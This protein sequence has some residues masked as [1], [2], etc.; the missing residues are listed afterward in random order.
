MSRKPVDRILQHAGNR[1]VVLRSGDEQA[2]RAG[3][4]VAQ[5]IH[6][7]G[8]VLTF[9]V[10]AEQRQAGQRADVDRHACRGALGRGVK[11]H[12]VVRAVPEASG[13]P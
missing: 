8:L 11:Q 5:A 10:L 2:V 6:S 1:L 12:S 13:D 3:H 9:E 4:F 7:F